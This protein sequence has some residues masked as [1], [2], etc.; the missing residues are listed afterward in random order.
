MQ[1]QSLRVLGSGWWME[2]GGGTVS[3][4]MCEGDGGLCVGSGEGTVCPESHILEHNI[5]ANTYEALKHGTGF[6]GSI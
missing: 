1:K 2:G 5:F 3:G 6:V 4:V